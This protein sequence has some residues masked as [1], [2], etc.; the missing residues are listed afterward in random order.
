MGLLRFK[1]RQY[2]EGGPLQLPVIMPRMLCILPVLFV[3]LLG[4]ATLNVIS[5]SS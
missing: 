1:R 3:T 5:K 4:P 2:V